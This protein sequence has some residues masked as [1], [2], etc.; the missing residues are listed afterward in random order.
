[1]PIFFYKKNVIFLSFLEINF[2][3]I[4]SK[5]YKQFWEQKNAFAWQVSGVFKH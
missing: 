3:L 4:Y 2:Q 5:V 1:M